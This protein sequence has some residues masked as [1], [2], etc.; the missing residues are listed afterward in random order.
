MLG[1]SIS[2]MNGTGKLL[3]M[4]IMSGKLSYQLLQRIFFI[5]GLATMPIMTGKFKLPIAGNHIGLIFFTAGILTWGIELYCTRN[6]LTSWEQKGFLFIGVMFLWAFFCTVTGILCYP[7][8]DSMNLNQMS[9]FRNL[10]FNLNRNFPWITELDFVKSFLLYRGIR[11]A[12]ASVLSTYFISLWV[13]HIYQRDWNMGVRDIRWALIGAGFFLISY[14]SIEIGFL[15]GNYTCKT[16]LANINNRIFDVASGNGWYPPLFWDFLQLRSLFLEPAHLCIFLIMA[17]PVL[18]LPRFEA[19]TKL[20]LICVIVSAIFLMMLFMTKSR[21]GTI[22]IGIEIVTTLVWLFITQNNRLK[23]IIKLILCIVAVFLFSLGIMAN[24]HSIDSKVN[25]RHDAVTVSNYIGSNVASVVGDKRSNSTRK[26]NMLATVKTWLDHP[27]MGVGVDLH[28][29][30]VG[31]KFLPSDMGNREAAN[32]IK[33][34][35]KEGSVKSGIPNINHILNILVEQGII[36]AIIFFIP[37][38]IVL[39]I[40]NNNLCLI[41]NTKFASLLVSLVGS[42]FVLLV[43]YDHIWLFIIV[44]LVFSALYTR[45]DGNSI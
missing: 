29:E 44:G 16:L 36:G 25:D 33:D 21:T 39:I 42:V 8:F 31:K 13:Y 34:M 2:L 17:I 10:Y 5:I 38:G 41:Y 20:N 9:N 1:F 19:K 43:S 15:S 30:Y 24:F 3:I 45:R 4:N 6:R 18:F 35:N 12:F 26:I 7:T 28:S 23:K 40:C 37:L 32:W 14:S 11:S 22:A 27:L